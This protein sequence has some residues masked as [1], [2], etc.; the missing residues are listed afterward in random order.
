MGFCEVQPTF[1]F[2]GDCVLSCFKSFSLGLLVYFWTEKVSICKWIA[3]LYGPPRD[4][5]AFP[6]L[7]H[8][9]SSDGLL[10]N[11]VT[12]REVLSWMFSVTGHLGDKCELH[13]EQMVS[14]SC[15]WCHCFASKPV[16]FRFRNQRLHITDHIL[17]GF[18]LSANCLLSPVTTRLRVTKN[19]QF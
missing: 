3:S 5:A 9:G 18:K 8:S 10:T 2:V 19:G 4:L 1:T 6:K 13:T 11:E 16:L 7:P 17:T 14:S 15:F 12:L